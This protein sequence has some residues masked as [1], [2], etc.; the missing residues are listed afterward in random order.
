MSDDHALHVLRN[1]LSR[2]RSQP[3][4]RDRWSSSR[5]LAAREEALSRFD[6]IRSPE[7][8]ARIDKETFLGFLRFENKRHRMGFGRIGSM[9]ADMPRLQQALAILV[10]ERLPL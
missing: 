8:V 1:V 7:L 4:E 6:L 10:D 3:G 5:V 2:L 9:A